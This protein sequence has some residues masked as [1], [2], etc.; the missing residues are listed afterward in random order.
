MAIDS[1]ADAGDRKFF[2]TRGAKDSVI[3]FKVVSK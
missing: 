2:D 1:I 3:T